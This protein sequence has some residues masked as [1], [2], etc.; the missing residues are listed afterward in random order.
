M[1]FNRNTAVDWSR[2]DRSY[3]SVHPG[4]TYPTTSRWDFAPHSSTDTDTNTKRYTTRH[5]TTCLASWTRRLGSRVCMYVWKHG[6]PGR[7]RSFYMR[8][9]V[10]DPV[11]MYF[12]CLCGLQLLCSAVHSPDQWVQLLAY[13][14]CMHSVSA[15]NPIAWLV[16][17][18]FFFFE[19]VWMQ[20]FG[21]LA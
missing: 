3:Y 14:L 7:C 8:Y 15:S 10:E 2:N 21:C 11:I 16:Q 6:G 18:I 13:I 17:T 4:Y 5:D 12:V 1:E 9:F 20:F 19:L